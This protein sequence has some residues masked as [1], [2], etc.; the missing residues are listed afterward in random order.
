M[1]GH[2]DIDRLILLELN[3]DD[4]LNACQI[5]KYTY[6]NVCNDDFY[7]N[8]LV[9]YYPNTL[10]F[11]LRE[12]KS[13]VEERFKFKLGVL[14]KSYYLSVV[15]Y[16][17]NLKK[18]YNYQYTKG[19]PK[20][21]WEIFSTN[22]PDKFAHFGEKEYKLIQSSE[23]GEF[24][25]VKYFVS[26]GVHIDDVAICRSISGYYSEQSSNKK[27]LKIIKYLID[28]R[29]EK[30]SVDS[31]LQMI[32]K[33]GYLNRLDAIDVNSLNLHLNNCVERISISEAN[34][35]ILKYMLKKDTSKQNSALQMSC[36]FNNIEIVK[37]LIENGADVNAYGGLPILR[38]SEI[39]SLEIVKYLVRN[40]ANPNAEDWRTQRTPLS[41]A[42]SHSNFE[43]VQ[44][45]VEN[46]ANVNGMY[47]MPDACIKG[48]LE[49][50]QYL[51]ENGANV[52]DDCSPLSYA[53]EE[54]QLEIVKFLV[55]RGAN[56]NYYNGEPEHL[57][58]GYE[59]S[60][61]E[62]IKFLIEK[63]FAFAYEALEKAIHRGHKEIADYLNC[64]SSNE[65]NNS[66][67]IGKAELIPSEE[68]RI[69][70]FKMLNEVHQIKE[71]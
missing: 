35:E 59:Q 11:E 49:I 62:I 63:E 44:F 55:E 10:K 67:T 43:M 32:C 28:H 56:I 27:F 29:V 1:I 39:N 33:N 60:H 8:R 52:N 17:S 6:I 48:P 20:I 23:L 34:I 12:F 31:A 41:E 26:Q 3:D 36:N 57:I 24:E 65:S 38:A 15:Y 9:K 68:L 40:G 53:C 69:S 71:K 42:C 13:N 14:N 22:K 70:Y 64:P 19:N 47:V 18:H 50:V 46:G 51:V 30:Y 5:N 25:L 4:F 54:G 2:K 7:Y 21:Q 16:I 66:L 45:L 61:L 58:W 37:Y